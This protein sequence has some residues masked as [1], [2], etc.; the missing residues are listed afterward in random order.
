[1]AKPPKQGKE[2]NDTTPASTPT[3]TDEPACQDS[4]G[5]NEAGLISADD[6][7]P[8][9]NEAADTLIHTEVDGFMAN[10]PPHITLGKRLNKAKDD[11]EH[12]EW[13]EWFE[14]EPKKFKFSMRKAQRCMRWAEY[15]PE[16]L[17]W[18]EENRQHMADLAAEGQQLGVEDVENFIKKL[19]DM[20]K[21]EAEAKAEAEKAKAE[22]KA[23]SDLEVI[24]GE[25]EVVLSKIGADKAAEIIGRV[26]D[27]EKFVAM[28]LKAMPPA[29]VLSLLLSAFGEEQLAHLSEQLSTHLKSHANLSH[30]N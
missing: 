15:E 8:S 16:L 30:V 11:L 24:L 2:P 10:L 23:A 12:G 14:R 26:W 20:R 3:N 19:K 29:R 25:L 17:A 18:A 9:I 22:A 27:E 21:A 5:S 28:Q 6:L 1:M 13:A 4:A 7:V